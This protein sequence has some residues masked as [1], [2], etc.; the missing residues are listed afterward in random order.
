MITLSNPVGLYMDHIDTSG[1]SLPGGIRIGDCIKPVRGTA[2]MIER[3]EVAMPEG[4]G[5]TLS[6]ITIGG[7]PLRYGGQIAECITIKLTG[8]ASL[9]GKVKNNVPAPPEGMCW[10][11]P[12][13]PAELFSR[14]LP[15]TVPAFSVEGQ[16]S[17]NIDDANINSRSIVLRRNT[18]SIE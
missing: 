10:I 6:D 4:S 7:E 18:R 17:D 16:S 12:A 11:D 15:G 13:F 1:W 14:Y 2:N 9:F 5:F 3:L 8:A